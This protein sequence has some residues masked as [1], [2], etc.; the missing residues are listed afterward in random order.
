LQ[1]LQGVSVLSKDAQVE[2]SGG[3]RSDCAYYMPHGSA[4]GG[5]VASY[6]VTMAHARD[7]AREYG[8]RWCCDGCG[9]ASWYGI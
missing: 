1:S 8:G 9:S 2:V 3:L 5:P 6:N 4:T 7:M